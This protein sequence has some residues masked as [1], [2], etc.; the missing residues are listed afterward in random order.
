MGLASAEAN[1]GG[2]KRSVSRGLRIRAYYMNKSMTQLV[3]GSLAAISQDT[4]SP[5]DKE[6]S[7]SGHGDVS[8]RPLA[9]VSE[10]EVVR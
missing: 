6:I 10:F 1:D 8:L 3:T 9:T 2:R 5:L 7:S 4:A